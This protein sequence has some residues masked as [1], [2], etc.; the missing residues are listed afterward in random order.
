MRLTS[1]LLLAAGLQVS[2]RTLSQTVTFSGERVPLVKVFNEVKKQTGFLVA[3]NDQVL[4]SAK[5]VSISV[6]DEPVEKF[7]QKVLQDQPFEYTIEGNTIFIRR[8]TVPVAGPA[9]EISPPKVFKGRVLAED[10]SPLQGVTVRIKGVRGGTSTDADGFFSITSDK[11][12]L[13]LVFSYV[14][15]TETEVVVSGS[16]AINIVLHPKTKG[17]A[18]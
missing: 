5:P 8:R 16:D 15:Y 7:M 6:K 14:G 13:T 4:R 12:S 10:S 3:Y 11:P 18:R 17:M 1:I 9:G 2:A